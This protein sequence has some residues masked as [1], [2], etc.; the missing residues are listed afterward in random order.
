MLIDRQPSGPQPT[1]GKFCGWIARLTDYLEEAQSKN[2]VSPRIDAAREARYLL[3]SVVG[4]VE[5]ARG[6][7][8]YLH[9]VEDA[10]RLTRDR[11]ACISTDMGSL[12]AAEPVR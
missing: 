12:P 5:L 10:V 7:G 2:T 3:C 1:G 4:L 11:L 8:A 6:T 9:L